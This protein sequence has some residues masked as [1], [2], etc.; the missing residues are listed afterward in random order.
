MQ[1][2]KLKKLILITQKN[3]KMI[4]V[5]W[6]I[7]KMIKINLKSIYKIIMIKENNN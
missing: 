7:R 4:Q 5:L 1:K 3:N 2:I 6:N